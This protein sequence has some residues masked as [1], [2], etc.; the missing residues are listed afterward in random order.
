MIKDVQNK[1]QEKMEKTINVLK[2]NLTSVRAGRANPKLLDK[3]MVEYYGTPTPLKQIA[4]VSAPEPRMLTVQ[5][6]DMSALADIEK[7]IQMADLGVNPANDGKII[8]LAMPLL[9]EERRKELSK[10]VKKLGED[11]KVALRNER[12]HANDDIKKLHKDG[13]ITEDDVKSSETEVQ[14]ITDKFVKQVDEIVK[15]KEADIMEV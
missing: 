12:R 7:A 14:N 11:A 9:T 15:V 6:Y 5:P 4:A 2:D 8:R 1:L 13:E 10:Q 3:V